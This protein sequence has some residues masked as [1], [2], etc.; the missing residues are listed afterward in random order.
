MG[1]SSE[2]WRATA[3]TGR[4]L[5]YRAL[6][7]HAL[8][9]RIGSLTYT[10]SETSW[11]MFLIP[12]LPRA[13]RLGQPLRGAAA[14]LVATSFFSVIR[15]VLAGLGLYGITA[16][17][18]SQRTSELGLR[19]ALGAEPV[20]VA[21]MIVAEALGL[22]IVGV[23]LGL[24]T[25]LAATRLIRAKMFGVGTIDLPSLAIAVA[26]LIGVALVASYLPAR[27]AARLGPLEALRCD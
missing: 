27:R 26:V 16:Y 23:A 8:E 4:S 18:T 24:P 3:D 11:R 13:S 15:L 12:A 20:R 9:A 14:L 1:R 22:A 2:Q 7:T 10:R 19:L 5:N 6:M 25:G 21:R 17:A